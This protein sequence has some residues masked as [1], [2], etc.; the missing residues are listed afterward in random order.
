MLHSKE[1]KVKIKMSPLHIRVW[2][3]LEQMQFLNATF[4][5]CGDVSGK[6]QMLKLDPDVTVCIS[7]KDKYIEYILRGKEE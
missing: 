2:A 1:K 7:V 5:Y 4:L 6:Y 3:K